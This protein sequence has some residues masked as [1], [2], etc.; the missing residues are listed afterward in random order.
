[1]AEA[2]RFDLAL[3]IPGWCRNFTIT[4]NGAVVDVA[5]QNSYA[6]LKRC[7]ASGDEVRLSLVLPVERMKANPLVWQAVGSVALQRGPVVYCLEGGDNG[8]Q[9]AQIALPSDSKLTASIDSTLFGGVGVI[10]S[11]PVRLDAGAWGGGLYQP[12][13]LV[14]VS[15][16]PV[17]IKAIPYFLWANRELGEMQVWLR[18]K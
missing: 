7:W 11:D 17:T 2:T 6:H 5:L 3:R 12:E 13:S 4:V 1:M 18:E 10:G 14:P 9:L 15:T 8:T 16:T